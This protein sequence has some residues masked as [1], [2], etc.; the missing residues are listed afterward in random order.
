MKN[1]V[2]IIG[3]GL[4][5]LICAYILGKNGYEVTVLE[6][7][8]AIGG[9][10]QSFKRD[11]VLFDTGMHYIGSAEEGQILHKFWK[12]LDL[13]DNITLSKLNE[14]AFDIISL[15]DQHYRFAMGYERFADQLS[16]SF[17]SQHNNIREYVRR[18]RNVAES[19]PLYNLQEIQ[20]HV[21]LETEHIKSSV[22]GF[23]DSVTDDALL[24]KV[25][26]GNLPLYAGIRD[27]T[28]LY[29]HALINNFYIQSAYRI[30]G[31]SQSI[32]DTLA[33]SIRS[34]GGRVLTSTKVTEFICNNERMTSVKI[35][36]NSI[37]EG[38]YFISNIHP[39]AMID[40]I[41]TPLIRK[42]YRERIGQLD[43][44]V[45]S[46]T[47]YMTFKPESVPYLN[48]NFYCYD[49]DQVWGCENYT[50]ENWPL[51]YLFMHQA[52]E[53]NEKY[54][55]GALM[56]AYMNFQDVE[57]WKDTKVGKR[58]EDYEEF[59]K[60]ASERMIEVLN[61]SF[62]GI[63]DNIRSYYSSTPLT[64]L[65]YTGTKDGSMYG[66]V[67]DMNFPTQT[68]VSQRTKVPNLFMTGQN[69]NSHGILGV[70]IGSIVTCAEFLGINKI[71]KEI[72]YK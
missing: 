65:N 18:I 38:D 61:K 25:L 62:P 54:S 3:S 50:P 35:D 9:C 12:Y 63:K 23:I 19:S 30:V 10:L 2:V 8:P 16:E 47:L 13:A 64:Y 55:K 60:R 15:N 68:L 36:D 6:K 46:F 45:S 1:R 14:E 5:G 48:S 40:I 28:P 49:G 69:I 72:T 53:Q 34:F 51:N 42:A 39:Q 27:K 29:I 71:I 57:R 7:N 4:G 11:G 17:P 33:A 22:S 56:I 44:T 41:D 66:I 59:K 20:Q 32:A 70:T 26:A 67:R 58:G 24:R 21:F 52:T 37:I 31:G 43:N